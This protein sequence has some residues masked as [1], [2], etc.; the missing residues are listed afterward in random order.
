MAEIQPGTILKSRYKI[1][2]TLGH[3]GMG[4]VY[5]AEDQSLAN[6][7]AVK[8]NH[9]LSAHTSAQ[10]IR[11]ARLLASL[12]HPNLPRV[13]DYFIE[14]D[15]QYL[16]MDYVPGNDLRTLVEAKNSI[17]VPLVLKWAEQLGNA[18]N[19]LHNQNP[20]IYHRDV[21]PANIKVTPNGEVVLVDFGIAKTG[22][23]SQETQTGAWGY[24]PGFAPPEQVSGLRT[25]PYSDQFSLAAT[26]YYLLAGEPPVDSAQRMMGSAEL[27][28]ISNQRKGIPDRVS[29][30]V[31][32]AM[33][34][35]PEERFTTVADFISA[36]T[37]DSPIPDPSSTQKTVIG[38]MRKASPPAS[39]V[40]PAT[41]Q[42]VL[43]PQPKKS[44]KL[45][46][47]LGIAALVVLAGGFFL[48]SWLGVLGS[49]PANTNTPPAIVI[50]VTN[51]PVTTEPPAPTETSVP[52]ETAQPS[53]TPTA[54][55]EYLPL[56]GGGRVAFVS[57]RQADGFFQVWVMDVVQ[58][59]AGQI[60]GINPQ[61]V[62]FSEGNKSNPSWSPD[63]TKLLYSGL[64]T[65]IA[66]NKKPFLDDI[67]LL[68]LTQP[69]AEPVDLT[70]KVGDDKY[71]AWSP[72]GKWIAWTSLGRDDQVPMLYIM[73]ADGTEQRQLSTLVGERFAAWTL[74]SDY[75]MYVQI[76]NDLKMLHMR[77]KFNSFLD[78]R[79]FDQFTV[80]GRLGL[81]WEPNVSL[82][83]SMVAYSRIEGSRTN[84]F[85]APFADRGSVITQLTNSGTDATPFW[86]PD[87]KWLL[88][89]T[90]RDGDE[91]IYIMDSTGEQE[92]N[93][94]KFPS[95]DRDPA[96]QP[97]PL[98]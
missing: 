51:E 63:G 71:P 1:M 52:T 17:S 87:T 35:K 75:L 98:D 24:T 83:G 62:T 60:L 88:F 76:A 93:L 13:I 57:N 32:K 39:P 94:T 7:V 21:K 25:G 31:M 69:E 66:S 29:N 48:L 41:P 22:D 10:F 12:K 70:N 67:W 42:S 84:I 59:D 6:Q 15:S 80:A 95:T 40:A 96:W 79:K 37:S 2:Q 4:E 74:D 86:S 97:V 90:K 89:M 73:N 82:D 55:P 28:P 18:L 38:V 5:L 56:G 91:E 20:P 11:E 34:I 3:G 64:S 43:P 72:N 58:D 30:A 36:L 78:D 9:N 54:E 33:S 49:K 61:Q 50:V 14:D 92:T 46:W 27:V 26:L 23:P 53:P 65:G 68:D 47:I 16:V 8:A 77:D 44:G 85:T 45:G 81:V 19:Y